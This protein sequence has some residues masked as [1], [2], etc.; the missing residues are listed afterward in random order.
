MKYYE[1][2]RIVS[3]LKMDTDKL[4]F[5]QDLKIHNYDIGVILGNALDNAIE[6]CKKLKEKEHNAD[7]FIRF[8]SMQ[9]GNL[10]VIKIENS[11][12]GKL[13][14]KPK[15]EYPITD[16]T[17]KE[18]HGMGLANIKNTVEKYHGAMDF[19]VNGKIFILSIMVKNER[20]NE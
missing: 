9:K 15:S 3:D 6:A 20:G 12:D 19:K 18:N 17:D 8:T 10:L 13:L 4:F 11:F 1:A 14:Q 7:V 5:P 2:V 16:K